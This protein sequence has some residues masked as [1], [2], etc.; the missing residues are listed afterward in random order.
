MPLQHQLRTARDSVEVHFTLPVTLLCDVRM[1]SLRERPGST[2]LS[3]LL[4]VCNHP[5]LFEGR[6]IVSAFD[7]LPSISI[8]EP[9]SVLNLRQQEPGSS[10]RLES[11]APSA[12]HSMS[13]WEAAEV[14]VCITLSV[15][16]LGRWNLSTDLP[17]ESPAHC[18]MTEFS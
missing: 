15:Y 11:I 18:C 4:Q 7:M 9:S 14:K 13:A 1:S 10:V 5:D 2:T 3:A 6:S 16:V 12:L 17:W 8:Q